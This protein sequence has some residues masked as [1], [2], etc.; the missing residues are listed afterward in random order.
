MN[1]TMSCEDAQRGAF[2]EDQQR[3]DELQAL[4]REVATLRLLNA[5]LERV[6]TRDTLTPLY[7]RRYF[8]TALNE[9][10]SRVDRYGSQSVAIIVDVDHMKKIND[11]YGHPAG[12]FALMHLAELL[13]GAIRTGDVA[14]RI[15][16]DEFALVLD[17][18]D[19]ASAATKIAALARMI[20]EVPCRF[21]VHI[22]PLSASFGV[23]P[24][25]PGDS[26]GAI[27]ARADEA[28]YLQKRRR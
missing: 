2:G 27:L 8:I 11:A 1:T 10:I 14:A 19:E 25:R 18:M 16:G 7:N 5:E 26:D 21:G 15:G 24:V 28:M 20:E 4:R 6:A 9:R 22:L 17:E 3:D 13:S 12:D 23:T